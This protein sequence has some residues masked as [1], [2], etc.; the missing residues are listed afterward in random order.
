[1]NSKFTN[2]SNHDG[3]DYGSM[4]QRLRDSGINKSNNKIMSNCKVGW[5]GYLKSKK[6]YISIS[7]SIGVVV[8]MLIAWWFYSRSKKFPTEKFLGKE[9]EMDKAMNINLQLKPKPTKKE[10]PKKQKLLLHIGICSFILVGSGIL[11]W[12]GGIL[13]TLVGKKKEIIC[14]E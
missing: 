9:K 8:V 4:L 7:V 11:A 13:Q 5:V 6:I 3:V 10:K 1:M 14:N 12:K 2:I